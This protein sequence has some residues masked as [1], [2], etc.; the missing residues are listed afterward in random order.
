MLI[1]ISLFMESFKHNLYEPMLENVKQLKMNSSTS[2]E[3]FIFIIYYIDISILQFI[4]N[5]I[6]NHINFQHLM[7]YDINSFNLKKY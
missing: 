7:F 6:R 1:H 3:T 4:F 2:F 5:K